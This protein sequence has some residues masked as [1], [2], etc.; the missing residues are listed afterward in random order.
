LKA[1][2]D[3]PLERFEGHNRVRTTDIEEEA[4]MANVLHNSFFQEGVDDGHWADG[5]DFTPRSEV[6]DAICLGEGRWH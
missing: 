6:A 3:A 4:I 2:T 5:R 1:P